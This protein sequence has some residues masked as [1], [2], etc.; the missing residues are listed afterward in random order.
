MVLTNAHYIREPLAVNSSET[1]LSVTSWNSWKVSMME[2]IVVALLKS[3]KV[4]ISNDDVTGKQVSVC[5]QP[6]YETLTE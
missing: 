1:R 3:Q 6:S 4:H 5:P 2:A